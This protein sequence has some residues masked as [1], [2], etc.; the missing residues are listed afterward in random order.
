VRAARPARTIQDLIDHEMIVTAH[1][2]RF[3]KCTHHSHS[4]DLEA[5]REARGPD[6]VIVGN[7][8]FTR[9]LVRNS[10]G[11]R[12]RASSSRR[13]MPPIRGS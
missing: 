2:G 1:C 12:V 3:P 7:D 10:C 5:L 9:A 6:Y 8:V 11:I 4:I 13:A